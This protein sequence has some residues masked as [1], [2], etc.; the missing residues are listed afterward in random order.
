MLCTFTIHIIIQHFFDN[1]YMFRASFLKFFHFFI[2][3][4]ILL[5]FGSMTKQNTSVKPPLYRHI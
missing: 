1:R 5:D 3:H 4:G 2:Y